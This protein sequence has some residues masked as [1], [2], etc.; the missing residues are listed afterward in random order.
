MNHL[1]GLHSIGTPP[2]CMVALG[3]LVGQKYDSSK[4]KKK[5]A[6]GAGSGLVGLHMKDA[7]LEGESSAIPRN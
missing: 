3:R 6:A 2:S 5:E 4:K 1:S 7:L